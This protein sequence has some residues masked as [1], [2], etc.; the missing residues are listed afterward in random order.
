MNN[1]VHT[2]LHTKSLLGR[3]HVQPTL[4]WNHVGSVVLQTNFSRWGCWKQRSFSLGH[5]MWPVWKVGDGGI[6]QETKTWSRRVYK[7]D[8][9]TRWVLIYDNICMYT[10]IYNIYIPWAPKTRKNKGFGHLKTGLFTIKT[11][12]N[13]GLGGPWYIYIYVCLD[14][15]QV[16]GTSISKAWSF[17]TPTFFKLSKLLSVGSTNQLHPGSL[18]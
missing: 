14:L 11:S 2:Y 4:S 13:V 17:Q 6:F 9:T 3:L 10:C 18:T 12:K 5:L 7:L 16:L 8:L 1:Y 15:L